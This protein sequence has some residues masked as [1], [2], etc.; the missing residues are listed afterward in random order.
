VEHGREAGNDTPAVGTQRSR[1]LPDRTIA[2][3]IK[4]QIIA[5]PTRGEVVVRV[6]DDMGRAKRAR[7]VQVPGA[8]HAGDLGP[9]GPGKLDGERPDAA[10]G[11]IDQHRLPGLKLAVVAQTL[12]SDD[13]RHRDGRGFLE[14]QIGRFGHQGLFRGTDILGKGAPTTGGEIAKDRIAGL[15][16]PHVAA[17]R[18]DPPRHVGAEHRV[19]WFEQ[20]VPEADQEGCA[21]HAPPV[22]GIR[23]GRVNLHQDLI[24]P[25]GGCGDILELKDIRRAV[26]GA[27]DCFHADASSVVSGRGGDDQAAAAGR[28]G[29]R[30]PRAAGATPGGRSGR[31]V[32]DRPVR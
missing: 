8:A 2:D 21:A 17:N 14:G 15:E 28:G 32:T 11:A 22:K 5:L 27:D 29:R 7:Q 1:I 10:R 30:H 25:G 18:F 12:E 6:V 16:V 13:A 3:R 4:D 31:R 20:P 26:G 24:G 19:P 23:G 9:E